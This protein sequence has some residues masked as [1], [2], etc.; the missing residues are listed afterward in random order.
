MTAR[1][2]STIPARAVADERL[3]LSHLR[4]L[5]RLGM[6]IDNDGWCRVRQHVLGETIAL[7]RET[8]NRR[9]KDLVAWGYVAKD[10][11]DSTGRS[12]FYRVLLDPPHRRAPED[13]DGPDELVGEEGDAP[14][15][16]TYAPDAGAAGPVTARSQVA[17]E[18]H[19]TCDLPRH[20]WCDVQE[21]TPGVIY[22][23]SHITSSSTSSSTTLPPTP[24]PG[25]DEGGREDG[26]SRIDGATPRPLRFTR[27]WDAA[28][29][30]TVV[31]LTADPAHAGVAG[32]VAAVCGTLNPPA[33]A[34]GAAW[35]EQAA[36]RLGR[37]PPAVLAE[38][39]DRIIRE[40][41]RD[42]PAVGE[43]EAWAA[44][45]AV[46][47]A[48]EAARAVERDRDRRAMEAAL[49]RLAPGI[50]SDAIPERRDALALRRVVVETVPNGPHLDAAWLQDLLV[51]GR[52]TEVLR[53][54][55]GQRFAAGYLASSQ[56]HG[57]LVAAARRLWPAI[58][59]IHA[60]V[61]AAVARTH[62][63]RQEAS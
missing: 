30:R 27:R 48:D 60:D 33:E 37:Q 52:S 45:A 7:S 38:V 25:G 17:P 20:T 50:E 49:A 43:I 16:A 12:I 2:L 23:T 13:A 9:L 51:V 29:R 62:S 41:R 21:I 18:L 14:A 24:R 47:Q 35:V 8:V 4:L 55:V 6:H 57:L 10:D 54:T 53:L 63:P 5:C 56:M 44:E 59:V 11:A 19:T 28:A 40:R 46:R 32:L 39:T 58:R 26:S 42:L 61:H 36:A 22:R 3:A 31:D 1:R 15:G 34:D